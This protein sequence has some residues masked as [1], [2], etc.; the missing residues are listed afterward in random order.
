MVYGQVSARNDV[1]KLRA[2]SS[3]AAYQNDADNTSVW[4]TSRD[5][6]GKKTELVYFGVALAPKSDKP[7]QDLDKRTGWRMQ[8]ASE[9]LLPRGE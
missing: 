7:D 5:K 8:Q 6:D 2:A 9:S 1:E 3:F 4:R